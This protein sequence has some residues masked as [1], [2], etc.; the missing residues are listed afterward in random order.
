M[1]DD[2]WKTAKKK[3]RKQKPEENSH[4]SDKPPPMYTN[5]KRDDKHKRSS[6]KRHHNN[7]K[8]HQ[9]IEEPK[10]ST[11]LFESKNFPSLSTTEVSH[12]QQSFDRTFTDIVNIEAPPEEIVHQ[13]IILGKGIPLKGPHNFDKIGRYYQLKGIYHGI[14][15]GEEGCWWPSDASQNEIDHFV[16]NEV[17]GKFSTCHMDDNI[18]CYYDNSDDFSE[19]DSEDDKSDSED[20]DERDYEYYLEEFEIIDKRAPDEKEF[21]S[22]KI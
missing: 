18:G 16:F 11:T 14:L 6:K 8:I 21:R 5:N 15:R 13:Q 4:K 10:K 20:E 9:H 19:Y 2:T 7:K 12:H 17:Y 1:S 22:K 3:Q